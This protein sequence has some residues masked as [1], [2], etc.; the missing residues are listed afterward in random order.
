MRNRMRAER[1]Q[2]RIRLVEGDSWVSLTR[3]RS[4]W[5]ERI[6]RKMRRWIWTGKREKL[7]EYGEREEERG[8]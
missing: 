5:N 6:S 8:C 7:S 2:E 4:D 1:G 3:I